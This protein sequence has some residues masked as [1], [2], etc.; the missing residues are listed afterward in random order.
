MENKLSVY[1]CGFRNGYSIRHAL[2]NNL[3]KW[4]NWL[5]K[6]GAIGT[7]LMDLLKAYDCIQH[8]LLIAKLKAYGF[9]KKGLRFL[10]SYLSG[11]Y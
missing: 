11:R 9:S 1:L 6:K 4:K 8:D 3:S 2:F 10:Q 5:D 7:I